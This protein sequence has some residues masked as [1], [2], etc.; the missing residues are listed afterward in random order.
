M[1]FKYIVYVE[2]APA[3]QDSCLMLS[4]NSGTIQSDNYPD[5]YPS[6]VDD[7]FIITNDQACNW[8]YRINHHQ[9]YS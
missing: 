4:D 6:N 9:L 8:M 1:S 5:N 2:G 7:C 3:N